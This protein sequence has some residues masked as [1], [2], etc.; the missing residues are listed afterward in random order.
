MI[1]CSGGDSRLNAKEVQ[2]MLLAVNASGEDK[3]AYVIEGLCHSDSGA[4]RDSMILPS[5]S[6]PYVLH[7]ALLWQDC[8]R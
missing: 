3:K 1:G 7:L 4:S 2:Y 5:A 6:L 8:L